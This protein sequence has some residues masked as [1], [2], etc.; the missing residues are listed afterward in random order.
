MLVGIPVPEAQAQ[1]SPQELELAVAAEAE[2]LVLAVE[3]PTVEAAL[4]FTEPVALAQ[5]GSMIVQAAAA[6]LA[7]VQERQVQGLELGG[8]QVVAKAHR[9]W[10]LYA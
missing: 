8:Q 10:P 4:E 7:V 3:Q 5:Q 2:A 1:A 9:V 6:A